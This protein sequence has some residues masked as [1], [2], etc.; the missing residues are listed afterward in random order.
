MKEKEK[1]KVFN[2]VWAS[3]LIKLVALLLTVNVD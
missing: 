1:N 2:S 3:G